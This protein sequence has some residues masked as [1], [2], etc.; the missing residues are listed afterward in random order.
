M[1]PDGTWCFTDE[2]W[3]MTHMSDDYIVMDYDEE[4]CQ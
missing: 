4:L 1:W 2:L 3:Q